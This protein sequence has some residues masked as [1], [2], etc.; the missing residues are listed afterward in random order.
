MNRNDVVMAFLPSMLNN[1]TNL[2]SLPEDERRYLLS[3]MAKIMFEIADA[4]VAESKNGEFP[5]EESR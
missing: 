5:E 2:G 3:L 1:V 4:I